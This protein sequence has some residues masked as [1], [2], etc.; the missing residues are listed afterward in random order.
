MDLDGIAFTKQQLTPKDQRMSV[1]DIMQSKE[2]LLPRAT[3]KRE[4]SMK[5]SRVSQR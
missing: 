1:T 5:K 3:R 4:D 2:E